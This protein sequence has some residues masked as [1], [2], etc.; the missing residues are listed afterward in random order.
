MSRFARPVHDVEHRLRGYLA[1]ALLVLGE[2]DSAERELSHAADADRLADYER[3]TRDRA[4]LAALR[5]DAETADAMLAAVPGLRASE[6]PEDKAANSEVEAFTAAARHHPEDALRYARASLADAAAIGISD[7]LWVWPLAARAAHDLSD[8]SATDE[9]LALLDSYPPGYLAPMLRAE[10]DLACARLAVRDGKAGAAEKFASAISSLRE[11]STP[12]HLA[13]GLL[14]HAEYLT[15]LHD[16]EAAGAAVSEAR[17]I[18]GLLRCQ[19][20]L[21]R[22]ADLMPAGPPVRA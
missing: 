2:W 4:W 21:D 5:G 3:L 1:K 11:L 8:T 15:R 10:R 9:L 19:P 12:Y 20:L 6:N 18:A 14:D 17:E 7:L 13:H 16:G 22:A